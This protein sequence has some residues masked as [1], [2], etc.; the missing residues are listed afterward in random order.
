MPAPRFLSG[1]PKPL[2]FGL[3]GGAGGLLGALV[4][5]ELLWRLLA[6]PPPPPA[7]PDPQVAVA[8]SPDVEVFVDGRN[9][10]PVQV[11]RDGF[12]GPVTVRLA[13]LPAGVAAAPIV[14]PAGKT[15]GEVVVVGSATAAVGT[16]PV[17][18]A[19]EADAGGRSVSAEASVSL[20]VWDPPRARADVAFVLDVTASMQ[21]ALDDL[22]NGIGAFA[23]ALAQARVDFRLALVTFRDVARGEP[24]EVVRF[25][26]A[27]FTADGA[28]F[29]EGAGRLKPAGGGDIPESSFEAV[30]EAAR[31]P[32]RKEATK[33]MLLLT[34]G[35]P[36]GAPAAAV[37]AVK[38]AGIDAVHTVVL[39]FDQDAYGPL[40][41][42][43]TGQGGGGRYFN[44]G[45][46]VRGDEG[47]DQLLAAFGS[48]VTEAA[49]AKAP[50]ATPQVSARAAAPALGVRSLQGGEQGAAGSEGKLVLRSGA[51]TGAIAGLVCLAL[52]AGQHHYLRGTLPGVG[53]VAAGLVG[54]V[55]AGL[56]G[57][58]AGQ[59]LYGLAPPDSAVGTAFQVV[60]WAVLGG[61]AGVGLSLVIPNMRWVHGLLGGAA[62]G[63][64]GAAG[65]LAVSGAAG[66]VVGRLVGG[67]VVGFCI[68][69]MVA[70]VEAAFRRAWLEVR[71]GGRETVTVTLGPEPVK[72]GGDAR[73]CTVWARGA[74]GVALRFFV[75]DGRVV[76]DDA[77]MRR[78]AVAADGFTKDVGTVTVVVRTG[79]G[80]APPAPVSRPAAPAPARPAPAPLSL[81]DDPLPAAPVRPPVSSRP[82]PAPVVAPKPPPAPARPPV[83]APK[84]PAPAA[85]RP[86]APSPPKP[87]VPSP[88]KHPDACPGC[89]RVNPGKPGG[90]YCVVCDDTY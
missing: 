83:A 7:V 34:D 69:V 51:W 24:V 71:Y 11:A 38:A 30:A 25:G 22:R 26:G 42:A 8:A 53:A 78:E 14:I 82:P 4:F 32:F 23:D 1:L 12:D 6:P 77:V 40:R 62:G 17:R 75:R 33:L 50:D 36:K 20:K 9:A 54:G 68:G 18:V 28:A 70:V 57:G 89:G 63:A 52:L 86:P 41:E 64:L 39:R 84:P 72:V 49:R 74:P 44:L 80:A 76:C 27:E 3:Y 35:P 29:R 48:V 90:R 59:G 10:L 58:A 88:A 15:E 61:L 2:L 66:D 85:P 79:A 13:G 47:F 67:L 65:F 19:A 87:A 37:A 45:D 55:L 16:G 31:L 73:A 21:W 60:G 5:G 56:V 81:D 46:V 43:G